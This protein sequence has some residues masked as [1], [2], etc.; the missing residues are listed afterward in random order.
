[1]GSILL[2]ASELRALNLTPVKPLV[3]ILLGPPGAGKGTHATPLS[4]VL[5]LPHISTGDL[6]RA[7]IQSASPLGQMAKAYMDKGN[8]VPDELVL[9]MLFERLKS[10]DCM[11]GCILDGFPR[12]LAQAKVL[13]DRLENRSQILALNFHVPDSVLIDRIAGRLVCRDCKKPYHKSYD[14]PA[15][16]GLC[17]QCGG[18]LY[19]RDDDQK[20]I[21]CKRLEV[22]RD[23]TMPLI[24]YYIAKKDVLKEING[25]KTKEQVFLDVLDAL[26]AFAKPLSVFK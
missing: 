1:M 8:L 19:T 4:E 17:G 14:P 5:G 23:E 11:N 26:P 6:F 24:A 10:L 7:Q 25:Q 18:T 16:P 3:L 12:T 21:V 13:D 20:S 9:D 2:G 22:Y 15:E